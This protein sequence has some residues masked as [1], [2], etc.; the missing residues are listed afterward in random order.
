MLGLL[1]RATKLTSSQGEN[2]EYWT[3]VSPIFWVDVHRF[4]ARERKLSSARARYRRRAQRG[5]S[6]R[7][8]ADRFRQW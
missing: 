3:R 8:R 1:D 6:D 7:N 5:P 4:E 2:L